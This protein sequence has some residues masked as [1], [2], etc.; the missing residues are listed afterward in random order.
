MVHGSNF[1]PGT[2][3]ADIESALQ[4]VATDSTG[5]SGMSSCRIMTNHPTVMAEMVFYE[6][7]VAENVIA[8]FNN[9][10]A[11]GRIL[12]VFMHRSGP[13]AVPL[14]KNRSEPTLPTSDPAP[15]QTSKEL[16]PEENGAAD[17]EDIDMVQEPAYTESRQAADRER[18][19]RRAEPEVQDGRYGFGGRNDR[20]NNAD[21]QPP[22]S[23]PRDET[24]DT[25]T[26][27][28]PRDGDRR[29]DDGRDRRYD[30]SDYQRRDDGSSYRRDDRYGG[31][32]R[33]DRPPMGGRGGFGNGDRYGR[34]YSDD[35]MRGPRGPRGGG[36]R[37][38]Y[39]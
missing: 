14:P 7:H 20:S 26:P 18:E 21:S 9:Q 13:S 12:H 25:T 4:S 11:D 38:G 31:F 27:D 34:M 36:G 6:K 2:T 3:A 24:T 30:S 15:L 17:D 8:T 10:K 35:M 33:G 16:I 19:S 29:R 37:G 28:G 1:A 23:Q 22:P 39:R 5:A 32:S